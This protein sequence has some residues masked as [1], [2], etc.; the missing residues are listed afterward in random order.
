MRRSG[1][2]WLITAVKE[3]SHR[4]VKGGR[5]GE[6]ERGGGG[7]GEGER[8]RGEIWCGVARAL[9]LQRM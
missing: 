1:M 5:E 3:G 4:W 8:E 2:C 7:E 6:R 9:P